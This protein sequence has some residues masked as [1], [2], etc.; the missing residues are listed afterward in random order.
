[1]GHNFPVYAHVSCRKDLSL[2]TVDFWSRRC[3]LEWWEYHTE[4]SYGG[5]TPNQWSDEFTRVNE[6]SLFNQFK[7]LVGGCPENPLTTIEFPDTPHMSLVPTF[8]RT[9]WFKIVIRAGAACRKVCTRQKI[10]IKAEQRIRSWI[11][12]VPDWDS[13]YFNARG[14]T[15]ACPGGE[16]PGS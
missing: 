4:K 5:P 3:L 16:P 12:G 2:V 14:W 13:S 6:S 9:I 15:T 8:D 10:T 11:G 7:S 1:M